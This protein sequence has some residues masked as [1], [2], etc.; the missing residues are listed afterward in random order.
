MHRSDKTHKEIAQEF[1]I[2]TS[3]VSTTIRR[4]K[5]TG[6]AE[7]RPR[8]GRPPKVT[9]QASRRVLRDITEDP[10]RP[11]DAY[12]RE[13]GVSGKTVK[14]VAGKAGLHRRIARKKP[15][16]RQEHIAKRLE[17]LK[18]TEGLDWKRVIFTDEASVEMGKKGGVSWTIRR[19]NQ[20]FKHKHIIPTFKQGRQSLMI[21]GAIAHGHKW[22]L[23]LLTPLQSQRTQ[24]R[25][26]VDRFKYVNAVLEGCLAGYCSQMRREGIMDVRV[27]EDGA[28]IHRNALAAQAREELHIKNINHPPCSPDLN[29]IESLWGILKYRLGKVRPVASTTAML[30]EQIQEVWNG[31]EQHH[32][33][34]EVEKMVQKAAELKDAKGYHTSG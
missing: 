28:P 14:E 10:N 12:G 18:E 31:L 11:W 8:P 9:P 5:A 26:R 27:V 23:T 29:A 30:W 13:I 20:Q 17:W 33:D 21:F 7:S 1:D 4:F 2:P 22:P 16:L 19:P 32:V 3:S 34:R 25:E 15:Y 24:S 6:T